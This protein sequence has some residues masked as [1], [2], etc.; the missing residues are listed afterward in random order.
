MMSMGAEMRLA[1][2][3][4]IDRARKIVLIDGE[5]FPYYITEDGPAVQSP[6]GNSAIP[7]VILPVLALDLEIIPEEVAPNGE[8]S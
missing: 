3:I 2:K 1:Q 4:T 8:E 7:V 6:M 5:V